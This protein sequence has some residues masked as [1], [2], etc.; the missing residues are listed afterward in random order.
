MIFDHPLIQHKIGIL[1]EESTR[2]KLFRELVNEIAMLMAYEVTRDLPLFEEQIQTPLEKTVAMRLPDASIAIVPILRAGLGMV[3]GL[4]RILPNAFVGHIGMYRDH[5]T[6]NP[7]P[8]YCSL[9]EGIG[10]LTSIICDPMLAT[11]GSAIA[12]A[13]KLKEEGAGK[14]KFMCLIAAPEGIKA[15]SEA[16]PEVDIYA[17]ALDRELSH[18]GYILPGLGDAGDRLYGTA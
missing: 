6:L 18:N 13:A 5:E 4:L 15:L 14:I 9:P 11:G 2:S 17:A 7:V 3:D 10:R 16:Q 8:Y 1:R 12:A